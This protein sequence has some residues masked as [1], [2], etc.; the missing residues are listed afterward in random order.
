VT[1]AKYI[2]VCLFSCGLDSYDVYIT[3][4]SNVVD[5]QYASCNSALVRL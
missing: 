5:R 3:F 1:D 2:H 4:V